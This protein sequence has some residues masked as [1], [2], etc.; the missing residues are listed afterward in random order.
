MNSRTY[1]D[2][3]HRSEV[4]I[5]K[6]IFIAIAEVIEYDKYTHVTMYD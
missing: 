1:H 4:R 5:A 6:A 2:M 3:M